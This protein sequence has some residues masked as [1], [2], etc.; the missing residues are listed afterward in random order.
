M[1]FNLLV[2]RPCNVLV[3]VSAAVMP[4]NR[5]IQ[6]PEESQCPLLYLREEEKPSGKALVSCIL[7]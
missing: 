1:T 7:T 5:R 3:T 6:G 2:I 4:D